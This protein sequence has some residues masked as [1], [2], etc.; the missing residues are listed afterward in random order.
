[1]VDTK[2]IIKEKEIKQMTDMK[3]MKEIKTEGCEQVITK[4]GKDRKR[5]RRSIY[6]IATKTG[7][8]ETRNNNKNEQNQKTMGR[9]KGKPDYNE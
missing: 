9:E 3:K 5:Q 1:M 2:T 8:I 4:R 6:M 7:T